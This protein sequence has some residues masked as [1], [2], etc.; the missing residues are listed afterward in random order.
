MTN[1]FRRFRIYALSI[2]VIVL[3]SCGS[4]S[5]PTFESI[6]GDTVSIIKGKAIFEKNCSG[7]HNFKQA[8]IGPN[9]AGLTHKVPTDWIR[10]FIKD[11]ET[12]LAEGDVRATQ[13]YKKY[14]TLMPSFSSFSKSEV[15]HIIAFLHTFPFIEQPAIAEDTLAIKN[16][17]PDTVASSGIEMNLQL[18]AQIP[19]SSNKSPLTRIAKLECAPHDTNYFVLDQRGLL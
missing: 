5:S 17:V 6:V 10:H 8:G 12:M 18:V 7:C 4:N 3:T 1:F 13:L 9:L 19:A 2:L 15:D 14:Q 11:P 16:P